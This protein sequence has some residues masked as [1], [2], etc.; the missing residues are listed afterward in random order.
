MVVKKKEKKEK[1]MR[2]IHH[3]TSLNTHMFFNTWHH[4]I[5]FS[6]QYTSEA[7]IAW[8]NSQMRR[9][10]FDFNS[11][12]K[13]T[14]STCKMLHHSP[15]SKRVPNAHHHYHLSKQDWHITLICIASRK[16]SLNMPAN[17][18]HRPQPSSIFLWV[19]CSVWL[20][21]SIGQRQR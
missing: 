13:N 17:T 7:F 10:K 21:V 19:P 11:N 1:A 6:Q 5:Q 20:R 3:F 2:S 4:Y 14:S 8:Q 9:I 16:K 15:V 18:P 12:V